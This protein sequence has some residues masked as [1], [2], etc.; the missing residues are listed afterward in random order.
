MGSGGVRHGTDHVEDTVVEERDGVEAVLQGL[1]LCWGG[2]R[3]EPEQVRCVNEALLAG[4]EVVDVVAAV[5]DH[6]LQAIAEENVR[7]RNGFEIGRWES[8]MKVI[9]LSLTQVLP[10]PGSKILNP[11]S[12]WS[13]RLAGSS[14]ALIFLNSDAL[15]ALCLMGNEKVW[16][17]LLSV[18]VSEFS[19][20]WP[21]AGAV[22][23]T[24]AIFSV[25]DESRSRSLVPLDGSSVT[26]GDISYSN[27][28]ISLA[29]LRL[30]TQA[31][32]RGG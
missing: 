25:I 27:G 7:Q 18:T 5:L 2:Q 21:L 4:D 19:G 23:V 20:T 3:A 22:K 14:G 32:C 29:S 9:L 11:C 28:P 8:H 12:F 15:T 13:A 16:P 31:A 30:R 10:K 24:V 6:A 26:L 17:V 1:L